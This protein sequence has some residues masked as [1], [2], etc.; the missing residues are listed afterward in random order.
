MPI[1]IACPSC[2]ARLNAPDTAAGKKVK[3]PKCQSP[4]PVPAAGGAPAPAKQPVKK[5]EPQGNDFN[6]DDDPDER[7]APKKGAAPA[8]KAPPPD[9]DEDF[10]DEPPPPKKGA[11]AKKK[12]VDDDDFDDEPPPRKGAIKKGRDVDDEDFEEAP[13]KKGAAA[14]RKP[15]DDDEDD[16]YDDEPAPKK[17]KGKK[18]DPYADMP[19][20][21]DEEKSTA[22]MIYVAAIVTNM[23]GFGT[24][25][26]LV[27][28][29]MKKGDS[30][31]VDHTGKEFIN[32]QISAVLFYMLIWLVFGCGGGG[33]M[34]AGDTGMYVG[35]GLFVIAGLLSVVLACTYGICALIAAF[36]AKAGKW[37]RYPLCIHLLK[38]RP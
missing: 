5:A 12:P 32:V 35:I 8:K 21:S 15:V 1:T 7:P 11:A 29:L 22:F 33:A 31:F 4:I 10:D 20:P 36:K 25:G 17:G 16:D 6:F 24:L 27:W 28:W 3:C 9:E 19:E 23:I 2:K 18:G 14:K 38:V 30:K 37:Y 13:P 26:G 34:M